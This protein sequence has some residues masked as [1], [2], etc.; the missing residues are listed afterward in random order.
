MPP[1]GKN[2]RDIF[3]IIIGAESVKVIQLKET[4]NAAVTPLKGIKSIHSV[5]P[6]NTISH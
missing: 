4:G 1:D 3:P 6:Y 5:S 2:Q